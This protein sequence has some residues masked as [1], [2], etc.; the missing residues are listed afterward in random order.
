MK[1]VPKGKLAVLFVANTVLSVERGEPMRITAS[2][3]PIEP[4]S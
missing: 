1:D 2:T 4:M 3:Q